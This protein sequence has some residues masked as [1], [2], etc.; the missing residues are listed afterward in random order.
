MYEKIIVGSLI[1]MEREF[2]RIQMRE[3]TLHWDWKRYHG[4]DSILKCFKNKVK[5][6][7]GKSRNF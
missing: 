5:I 3:D 6:L 1:E 7:T 4:R 2:V